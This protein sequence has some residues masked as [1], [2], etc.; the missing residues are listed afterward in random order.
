MSNYKVTFHNLDQ[1]VAPLETFFKIKH[2]RR[3]AGREILPTGGHTAIF[4]LGGDRVYSSKCRDDET[5]SRRKGILTC[6]QK[7]ISHI[8]KD[9]IIY[10]A[11][12]SNG[13]V[14]VYLS[15]IKSADE[16]YWWLRDNTS[17]GSGL[18]SE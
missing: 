5:F 2:F 10:D 18:Y 17:L 14:S 12:F 16:A 7:M 8:T 9:A 15:A 1:E 3:T 4:E 11:K 13:G 6:L